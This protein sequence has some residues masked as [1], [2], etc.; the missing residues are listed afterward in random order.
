MQT[1]TSPVV[2]RKVTCAVCR[3]RVNDDADVV[4]LADLSFHAWCVPHCEVCGRGLAR[5]L[6]NDWAY[7]VIV[8]S[9][10]IGYEMVPIR[11][12]C[13]SCRESTLT[14]EPSPQD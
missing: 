8:I 9:S 5:E 3:R 14:S 7:Q 1:M 10:S 2:E 4:Q 13:A 6:E 11:H 12:V